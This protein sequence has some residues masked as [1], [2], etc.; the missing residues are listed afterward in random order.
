[1]KVLA[2]FIIYLIVTITIM[3]SLVSIGFMLRGMVDICDKLN[4]N[5]I[6]LLV[7][8]F[9]FGGIGITCALISLLSF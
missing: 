8:V 6:G 3:F 1:M 7:V 4:D 9:I 2:E 5:Q